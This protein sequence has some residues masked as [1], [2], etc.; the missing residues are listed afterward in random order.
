MT[1]VQRDVKS[2]STENAIGKSELHWVRPTSPTRMDGCR[3]LP[4]PGMD[5]IFFPV[6]LKDSLWYNVVKVL[7][8]MLP[9]HLLVRVSWQDRSRAV[10]DGSVQD[11]RGVSSSRRSVDEDE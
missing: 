5:Q 1:D 10:Q 11:T 6:S 3:S 2:T 9:D 8:S 4:I 7:T